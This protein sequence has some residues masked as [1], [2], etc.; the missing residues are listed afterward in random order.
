MSE[1][2]ST[3]ALHMIDAHERECSVR[4]QN[5]YRRLEENNSRFTR[6]ETMMWGL[7]A[8]LITANLLHKFV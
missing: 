6:I 7:Y 1:D 2:N 8:L 5:L 3:K 4:W